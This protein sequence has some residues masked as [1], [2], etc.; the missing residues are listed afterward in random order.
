MNKTGVIIII[1][2]D[3]DDQRLLEDAFYE[4]NL[5][6][7]RLYF[8]DGDAVLDYFTYSLGSP[9]LIFSDIRM[10]R[11]NGM[12]LQTALRK[13]SDV[14]LCCVPYLF[15]TTTLNH[16]HIV[17]AYSKS[18]QGF[19]KKPDDFQKLKEL[20]NIIITYWSKSAA[21]EFCL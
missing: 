8:N 13:G 12:E 11:V 10:P 4:L 6:N 1:E 20:L 2:D 5:P 19:F 7:E 15:L 14:A 18:C 9:F 3:Q 16:Q 17:D 21:V